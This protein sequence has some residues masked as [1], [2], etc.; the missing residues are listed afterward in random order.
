MPAML[1]RAIAAALAVPAI[2]ACVAQLAEREPPG[3][4]ADERRFLAEWVSGGLAVALGLVL[5]IGDR[6]PWWAAA[7]AIAAGGA[8]VIHAV[9]VGASARRVRWLGEAGA[10]AAVIALGAQLALAWWDPFRWIPEERDRAAGDRLVARIAEIEGEVWV[11]S[12]P[13]YGGLAGKRMYVHR[14]GYKDATG[15]GGPKLPRTWEVRGLEEALREHRFAAIVLD[16]RDLHTAKE[17]GAIERY[18]EEDE[19]LPADASPRLV[20]GAGQGANRPQTIWVPRGL[21]PGAK[22]LFDFEAMRDWPS[23]WEHTGTAWG[24]GP[25]SQGIGKQKI[26]RA[27]G[28]RWATSLH[29]D[30]TK[31]GVLTTPEFVIDGPRL[32]MRLGGGVEPELRVELVV[33][34]RV[35]RVATVPGP[36]PSDRFADLVMDV[37]ELRGKRARLR[38][39]DE[40]TGAWGHLNVDEIWVMGGE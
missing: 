4:I 13:W 37:A 14:M 35:A 29:Q 12:H 26:R 22:V 21:P 23:G 17:L 27:G 7:L 5:G 30:D 38:F 32:Q 31:T 2:A 40:A 25:E 33:D 39:V 1:H 9:I 10:A 18:Y 8:M 28:R 36:E 19:L 3:S 16:K 11:P 34:G 6:V 24:D 20:T 15:A